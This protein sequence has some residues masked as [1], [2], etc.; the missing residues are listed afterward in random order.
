MFRM[1]RD[2]YFTLYINGKKARNAR[3]SNVTFF[4]DSL[5]MDASYYLSE[6]RP[7]CNVVYLVNK[8][9]GSADYDK[10]SGTLECYLYGKKYIFKD[11]STAVIC[12]DEVLEISFPLRIMHGDMPFL[13][14]SDIQLIFDLEV[15]QARNKSFYVEECNEGG[16]YKVKM[17][18]TLWV[19]K[20]K[21]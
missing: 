17:I 10:M 20:A 14:I 8:L 21:K 2:N 13:A 16:Y 5:Y 11:F 19:S 15:K 1:D 6:L 9:G 4:N 7:A 3:F 12:G 18:S